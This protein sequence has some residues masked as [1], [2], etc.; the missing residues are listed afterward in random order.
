MGIFS[1]H[2][3][4]PRRRRNSSSASRVTSIATPGITTLVTVAAGLMLAACGQATETA[5]TTGTAGSTTPAAASSPAASTAATG[6]TSAG[7]NT[8]AAA[9][10]ADQ[11]GIAKLKAVV[12]ET[13]P[14]DEDSF[15]QGLEA[16]GDGK[17]LVG[18]GLNGQSRL[19]IS[20]PHTAEEEASVD[21]PDDYFGEGIAQYGDQIWQLTWR[22]GVAHRY[23]AKTLEPTGQAEYQGE[24]WGLCGFNDS[25]GAD[26]DEL[27]MSDGTATLRR[28][29]PVTLEE[30]G[31]V[32]V[33]ADGKPVEQLNELECVPAAES[34]TGRDEVYANVWFS[35]DILR[36]NPQDGTVE[37]IIDT[38]AVRNR[39]GDDPDN[40]LNGIAHIPGTQ[41][42]YVTGK[43]WPDLYRVSF[44]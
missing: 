32:E 20:D 12:H 28:M 31:R 24:G 36:I 41:E 27:L 16:T 33:T 5:G 2:P 1:S 19:Y 8:G 42:F 7:A 44:Q 11:G 18:T 10:G 14:F 3:A 22:N 30:R 25:L 23:D 37:A 13:L 17:L 4:R 34:S 40:V 38:S 39:A 15:T 29:D 9:D 43:R 6:S 35:T 21:L 26:S